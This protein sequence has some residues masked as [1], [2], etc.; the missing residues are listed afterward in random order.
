MV[1]DLADQRAD[2]C[3]GSGQDQDRV[4]FVQNLQKAQELGTLGPSEYEKGDET[5][6]RFD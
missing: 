3:V 6:N 2:P 5:V 1:T 4:L